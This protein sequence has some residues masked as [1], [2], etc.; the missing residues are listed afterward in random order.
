MGVH[1]PVRGSKVAWK[2][3]SVIR[4]G[5][6][7]QP[8]DARDKVAIAVVSSASLR[9]LISIPVSAG[10]SHLIDSAP[11]YGTNSTAFGKRL[12]ASVAK[13]TVETVAKDAIFAPLF[14]DDPRYYVLGHA[15]PVKARLL[16]AAERVVITRSD[17]GRSRFNAPLFLGYAVASGVDNAYYPDRDTGAKASAGSFASAL[18][19][20]VLGFEI[21]EFLVDALHITHLKRR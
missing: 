4:E 8:L 18:A 21:D 5:L 14:H 17:T 16:Y 15:K 20:A 1:A 19:G 2:Y 3:A 13:S 11:H 9:S 10:F 12:G 6:S 7:A